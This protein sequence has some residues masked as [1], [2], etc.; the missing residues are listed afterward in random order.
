MTELR[1]SY[2]NGG[3][4]RARAGASDSQSGHQHSNRLDGGED[5]EVGDPGEIWVKGPGVS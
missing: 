1:R 2:F 3:D 4:S 5:A